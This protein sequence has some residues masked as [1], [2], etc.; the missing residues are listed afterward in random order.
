MVTPE[1]AGSPAP[2]PAAARQHA[3]R[4]DE[5]LRPGPW[6]WVGVAAFAGALGVSLYPVDLTLALVV[7]AL[8]LAAGVALLV[9]TT[10][11]VRVTGDELHAGAAHVPLA[12]LREPRALTGPDLRH[13]LG[14]G[15]DARAHVCLRGWI[16]SAVRVELADPQDPT[17]YWIVSTRRPDELVAALHAR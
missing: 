14:P 3:A 1:P 13:A 5:A 2:T 11:H 12:L 8:A 16:R 17:P 7:A 4:F 15:L 9:R 6:G 10:P